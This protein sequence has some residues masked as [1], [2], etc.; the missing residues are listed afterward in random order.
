VSFS[1]SVSLLLFFLL[2]VWKI[3]KFFVF[4]SSDSIV[5]ITDSGINIFLFISCIIFQLLFF[6]SSLYSR[7]AFMLLFI[8]VLFPHFVSFSFGLFF[9]FSLF[10]CLPLL[11]AHDDDD[12]DD[13]DDV[14]KMKAFVN[15]NFKNKNT[16]RAIFLSHSFFIEHISKR[17]LF[18][19]SHERKAN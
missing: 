1:L 5:I 6:P 17:F 13:V 19:V 9:A 8:Y 4:S 16:K 12:D 10:V 11:A 18:C 7:S 14:D 2:A 15:C 3:I